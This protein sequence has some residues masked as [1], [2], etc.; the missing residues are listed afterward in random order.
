MCGKFCKNET[1][2]VGV[3]ASVTYIISSARC[4]QQWS[5]KSQLLTI[6]APNAAIKLTFPVG[7]ATFHRYGLSTV[8]SS[9]T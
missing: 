7:L 8:V 3:D 4:S 5:Q 6:I 9:F 2:T 1:E